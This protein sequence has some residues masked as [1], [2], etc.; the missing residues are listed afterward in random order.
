MRR[1]LPFLILA[2]CA[3][4]P[5][6]GIATRDAHAGACAAA[7]A[8]HVRK[9]VEAVET[10]FRETGPDDVTVFAVRDGSRLHDCRI[11]ATGRVLRLVH[12]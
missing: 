10:T 9:P 1:A 11:D 12:V 2:A 6:P 5:D 4:A 8:G 3:P 7:V